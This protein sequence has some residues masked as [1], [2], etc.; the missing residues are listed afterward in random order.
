LPATAGGILAGSLLAFVQGIGEFVASI[1]LFTVNTTPL[2][3][4]IFQRMYDFE[5]GAACAYGVLQ[6]A[7]I[8]A[9]LFIT[10]KIG[11]DKMGA[12]V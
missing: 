7:M 11:G 5:I 10:Q 6:I 9:V 3:V 4:A 8:V 12:S 1:L 2:S